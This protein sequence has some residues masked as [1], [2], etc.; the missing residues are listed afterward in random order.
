M[1]LGLAVLSSLATEPFRPPDESNHTA[2]A[3]AVGHGTI[4]HKGKAGWRE[5]PGQHETNLY[6]ADHP[7][8][9]YVLVAGP[10]L[11]GIHT[12]HP[13]LG[14]HLARFESAVFSAGTV[15][16]TAVLAGM[17][18]RRR[19]TV[20]G[21]AAIMATVGVFVWV[22]S[23][24]YNDSL[25][26]LLS[27]AVFLATLNVVRSGLKAQGCVLLVAAAAAAMTA[28]AANAEVVGIAAIG[29]VVAGVR[30][31]TLRRGIGWIAAMAA[32]C[33]AAS[34]WFYLL[35]QA[36]YG[37]L[38][39]RTRTW[40][41]P[42]SVTS[43]LF[44]P[45]TYAHLAGKTYDDVSGLDGVLTWSNALTVVVLIAIWAVTALGILWRLPTLRV[46]SAEAVLVAAHCLAVLLYVAWWVHLGGRANIRYLF[47]ALPVVAVV[48][49]A[50]VM[51]L[52]RGRQLAALVVT[53]QLLLSLCFL[54]K[55]PVQWT[56]SGFWNAFPAALGRAGVP[57]PTLV[58]AVLMLIVVG[59]W[60]LCLREML[61]GASF[62]SAGIERRHG[63]VPAIAENPGHG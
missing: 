18:T 22:S 53:G 33:F 62:P 8:L 12:G 59:G 42:R 43:F 19:E 51:S 41:A 21:S 39:G 27:I 25:A 55:L 35:N 48:V 38:T 4:P 63:R 40:L 14:F 30:H 29:L 52:P 16:L 50:A 1:F 46:R 54:A 58:T 2:Y 56:G 36:R 6:T 47:P 13:L 34:G 45:G 31:G 26:T 15:A 20:V 57:L 23:L 24:V 60:S 61:A 11:V 37:H 17:L 10:L 3:I 32:A 28:H 49:A 9:Y 7:P 5:I 44:S